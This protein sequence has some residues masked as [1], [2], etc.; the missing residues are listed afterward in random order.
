MSG[1][2]PTQQRDSSFFMIMSLIEI[3]KIV[4]WE[5]MTNEF[6]MLTGLFGLLIM[7]VLQQIDDIKKTK[8]HLEEEVQSKTEEKEKMLIHIVETLA[9]TIDAKDK[10][11]KGHSSRVAD[12]ARE[13]AR[14]FGYNETKLND[15]YMMGLLHDIGKIGVPDAIINKTGKLTDEEY[16]IM[17][18]HPIIGAKILQNIKE[19]SGMDIGAR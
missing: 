3:M 10:Y 14:R 12:Y 1:I 18:E 7:V 19:K 16:E 5:N 13:I 15:I 9:G 17:K 6:P 8:E 4:F 11:T 2:I